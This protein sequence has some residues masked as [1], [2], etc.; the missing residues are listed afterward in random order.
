MEAAATAGKSDYTLQRMKAAGFSGLFYLA[1]RQGVSY[2]DNVSAEV[3]VI[4]HAPVAQLDRASGF[5]PAGRR[6]NSCRAHQLFNRL[7]PSL[8]R[9][10][11]GWILETDAAVLRCIILF[12]LSKARSA[13]GAVPK[14]VSNAPVVCRSRWV[15]AG[16]GRSNSATPRFLRRRED[17]GPS[18]LQIPSMRDILGPFE[19]LFASGIGGRVD[20]A[21]IDE[22]LEERYDSNL[23][24]I[25]KG[26]QHA[27]KVV[28]E[29]V[30][31]LEG[32]DD[33]EDEQL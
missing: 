29:L 2:L 25:A 16:G 33:D 15:R 14:C 18:P 17:S 26:G 10:Y 8:N 19:K 24:K 21:E 22:I 5:E 9:Y 13:G 11:S 12:S 4:R 28:M 1:V 30:S 7:P 32:D 27:V 6:F 20:K 31:E 3:V 23:E